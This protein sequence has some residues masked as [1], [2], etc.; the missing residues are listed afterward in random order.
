MGREMIEVPR[1]FVSVVVPR[2]SERQGTG[3]KPPG[4][5]EEETKNGRLHAHTQASDVP[6]GDFERKKRQTMM[7]A[8]PV[9]LGLTSR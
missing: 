7:E 6:A 1:E 3:Q 5:H 2:V 9:S 4:R 8:R